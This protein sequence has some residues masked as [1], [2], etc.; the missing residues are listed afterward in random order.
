MSSSTTTPADTTWLTSTNTSRRN[1]FGKRQADDSA[2]SDTSEKDPFNIR[3]KKAKREASEKTVDEPQVLTG[4]CDPVESPPWRLGPPPVGPPVGDIPA[5]RPRPLRRDETSFTTPPPQPPVRTGT[6]APAP[7]RPGIAIMPISPQTP[8]VGY[9]ALSHTESTRPETHAFPGAGAGDAATDHEQSDSVSEMEQPGT[10]FTSS[11]S[12][13]PESAGRHSRAS[14]ADGE[15][16]DELVVKQQSFLE[17]LAAAE[18]RINAA[19]KQLDEKV[20]GRTADTPDQDTDTRARIDE[21]LNSMAETAE[22]IAQSFLAAVDRISEVGKQVARQ[23]ESSGD[24]EDSPRPTAADLEEM[25]DRFE[26]ETDILSHEVSVTSKRIDKIDSKLY[27]YKKDIEKLK[28]QVG[29][30]ENK[31]TRHTA[32]IRII[33]E[34]LSLAL[35]D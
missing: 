5:M 25:S 29:K 18:G 11:S 31:I 24:G 14:S 16:S 4:T 27:S 21:A 28:K 19:L 7:K 32:D 30:A 22:I 34:D 8:A 33:K 20:M 2:M 13:Y 35:D 6:Y 12:T 3:P 17:Q 10:F 26:E 9:D 1:L 15:P 23:A